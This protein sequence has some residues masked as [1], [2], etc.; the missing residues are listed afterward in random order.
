MRPSNKAYQLLTANYLL[1]TKIMQY[2]SSMLMIF[3]T[4]SMLFFG[5]AAQQHFMYFKTHWLSIIVASVFLIAGVYIEYRRQK[6]VIDEDRK[7]EMKEKRRF[8]KE[9]IRK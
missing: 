6:E 1:P 7:W 8:E 9:Q 4:I 2:F 3:A 5:Y